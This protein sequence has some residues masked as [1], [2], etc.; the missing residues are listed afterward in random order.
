MNDKDIK[1]L[2][3]FCSRRYWVYK[4]RLSYDE[5]FS[6]AS[7]GFVSALKNYKEESGF[8]FSTFAYKCMENQVRHE[9]YRD[10]WN[11]YRDC[12]DD[13]E[14]YVKVNLGSL[15]EMVKESGGENKET[16]RVE[17]LPAEE[18]EFEYELIMDLRNALSTMEYKYRKVLELHY[19]E[20]KTQNEIAEFFGITQVS[21]HRRLKKAMKIVREKM[22]V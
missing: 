7:L 22:G 6:M 8:K 20:N 13:K 15:N 1:L 5:L 14:V 21:V 19:F 2:Y 4:D 18:P 3:S 11:Y 10:K 17:L 16:E 12:R 9:I